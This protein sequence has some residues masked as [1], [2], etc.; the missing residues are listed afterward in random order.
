MALSKVP[1]NLGM[2]D[3]NRVMIAGYVVEEPGLKYAPGGTA[4]LGFEIGVNRRYKN[5]AD[6]WRHEVSYFDVVVLGPL[7]ERMSKSVHKTT[8]VIVEGE[9]RQRRFQVGTA[10]RS[11]VEVVGRRMQVLE[12]EGGTEAKTTDEH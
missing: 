1:K 2:P 11:K 6:E 9:L 12:K 4:V 7:A 3:L 10:K 5:Q 8:A